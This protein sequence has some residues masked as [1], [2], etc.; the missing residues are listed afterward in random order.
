MN[1]GIIQWSE[2]LFLFLRGE[3]W[4]SEWHEK[5]LK[6]RFYLG[7][8]LEDEGKR[9]SG[10]K[11]CVQYIREEG[12]L[13]VGEGGEENR[14]T[15]PVSTG[16][17]RQWDGCYDR[18]GGSHGSTS[19]TPRDLRPGQLRRFWA[20]VKRAMRWV[21][22]THGLFPDQMLIICRASLLLTDNDD[23]PNYPLPP[24]NI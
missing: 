6:E 12:E 20:E 18:G 15:G 22:N 24:I 11:G 7:E 17:G 16:R 8:N 3:A 13:G 5:R 10:L 14:V 4:C 1:G 2:S 23:S 19:W 21:M 9:E